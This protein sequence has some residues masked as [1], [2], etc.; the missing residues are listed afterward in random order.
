MR[1]VDWPTDHKRFGSKRLQ[2]VFAHH[3]AFYPTLQQNWR[4]AR[5]LLSILATLT[6]KMLKTSKLTEIH[7]VLTRFWKILYKKKSE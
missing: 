2:S 3:G 5:Y 6:A 7:H 1:R 4:V